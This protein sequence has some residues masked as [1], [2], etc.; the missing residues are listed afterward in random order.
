MATFAIFVAYEE[1]YVSTCNHLNTLITELHSSSSAAETN[2]HSSGKMGSINELLQQA[3][4]LIKQME[5]EV[6]SQEPTAKKLLLEKVAQHKQ[7][8]VAHRSRFERAKEQSQRSNLLGTKSIEQ[9]ERFMD[10]NDKL[11][12]Q[13]DKIANAQRTVAEVE[14]VGT[15]ITNELQRN[16]EKIQATHAKVDE[17][18]SITDSARRLVK[19]MEDREKCCIS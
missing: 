10:A 14:D 9:R 6:R 8:L 7:T 17:F 5:M 4:D 11:L 12:L 16:R 19:G 1:E 18:T 3:T 2:T 15:D 13:N